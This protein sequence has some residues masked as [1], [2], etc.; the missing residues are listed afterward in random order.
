MATRARHQAR[1]SQQV[2][3]QAAVQLRPESLQATPP[4]RECLRSAQGLPAH[5]H[6]LRQ[7]GAKLPRCRLPCRRYRMVDEGSGSA[8]GAQTR[9]K[10]PRQAEY[11]DPL[12]LLLPNRAVRL[13]N[14]SDLDVILHRLGR[15][16]AGHIAGEV[17]HAVIAPLF[18]L[19][20]GRCLGA[21]GFNGL[22]GRLVLGLLVEPGWT[23]GRGLPACWGS[24]SARGPL[25]PR[26][27]GQGSPGSCGS[28]SSSLNGFRTPSERDAARGVA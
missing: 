20:L 7:A 6:P 1:R 14:H 3:P 15:P 16:V 13:E 21:D 5:R 12:G 11:R 28:W 27:S 23:A 26:R 8:G 9:S 25:R 17:L 24:A 19:G 10:P 18:Q 22:L 2:E 4:H